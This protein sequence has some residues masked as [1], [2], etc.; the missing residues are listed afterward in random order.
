M[1]ELNI[2]SAQS[3][4]VSGSTT[5]LLLTGL[6]SSTADRHVNKIRLTLNN[7]LRSSKYLFSSHSQNK[8]Y[9]A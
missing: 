3:G 4:G 9:P 1:N 5:G 7:V 8:I 2:S 6:E